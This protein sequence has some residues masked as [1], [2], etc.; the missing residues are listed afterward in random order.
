LAVREIV[1][2]L[3]LEELQRLTG[4]ALTPALSR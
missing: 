3:S 1:E 2:G 4:A